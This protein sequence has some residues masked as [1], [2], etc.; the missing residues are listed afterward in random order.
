MPAMAACLAGVVDLQAQVAGALIEVQRA[1]W[2]I[3]GLRA[4]VEVLEADEVGAERAR[5]R[6]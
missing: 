2:K 1:A 3:A 4:V 5:S 6:W